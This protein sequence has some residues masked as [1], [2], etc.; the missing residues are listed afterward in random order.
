VIRIHELATAQDVYDMFQRLLKAT[1]KALKAAGQDDSYNVAITSKWI[2]LIPRSRMIKGSPFG[3]NAQGMLGLVAVR[4]EDEYDTWW[5][6][7]WSD[8]LRTLGIPIEN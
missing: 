4:D 6:L 2:A 8:H 3:G 1:M 5:R 7:G